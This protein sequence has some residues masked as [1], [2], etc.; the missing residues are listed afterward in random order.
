VTALAFRGAAELVATIARGEL[1]S[2]E[3]LDY[4]LERI[5]RLNRDLNAVV[6]LDVE[7]ARAAARRADDARA[8]GER[9]GPLHG[10]PMTV[11]DSFE[12]AGLRTT[13]G[14]P[15][16]AGYVPQR[17]ATA[18]QRLRGA[19]AVIFGK[20]NLPIWAADGQSYN[21]V[22]GTTRNPW[23]RSRSP[24]GSSGGAAA[25]LAAG[26][27]PLELGSDIS[28]SIRNPAH[29]CGVFGLK[30]SFG[31]VPQHGYIA[32]PPRTLSEAD[33]TVIGPLARSADDLELALSVLAGPDTADAIAW[34]FK[35]PAPRAPGLM[36]YR[37]AAW[38]D[39]DACPVDRE[40]HE[41]LE[42]AL[43]AL[44]RAGASVRER[45][46]PVALADSYRVFLRLLMGVSASR[47][48]DEEFARVVAT[49]AA[50]DAPVAR[51]LAQRKREWNA[52]NEE[53]LR[54]R[55][56][57]AEFFR[58]HDALLCPVM[59][60]PAIPHD[61]AP[62]LERRTILVNDERR[63]YWDQVIWCSPAS[64]AYLPAAVVPVG[65]TASGLP[66]GLQVVA[67]YLEDRTAID[68]A[69]R[70]AEILGGF[71]PPPELV[72]VSGTAGFPAGN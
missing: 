37:L 59:L 42:A 17:D 30:T 43:S 33:M 14:A 13:C 45:P 60:V 36:S 18:V 15:E 10:L 38:L 35:L 69:R 72:E 22:F 1:S 47:L 51:A 8:R 46:G 64:L 55:A 67:P 5:E 27:T 21:E 62:G 44:E 3:L 49:A 31:I 65:R 40:V 9:L 50:E 52:T 11:K 71:E 12:T 28:S 6:T 2:L 32:S 61:H 34:R 23:D 39:D 41:V 53:R 58:D 56:A 26:L 4:H 7:R 57:W 16:L 66:V 68:I 24:G 48:S 19:G 25:A 29:C 20:T 70:I 63:P 54:M